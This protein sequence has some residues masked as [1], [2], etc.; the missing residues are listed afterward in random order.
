MMLFLSQNVR[1]YPFK[2]RRANCESAVT[3]LPSEA[4]QCEFPM[5][6]CGRVAFQF[7]HNVR[8][9]VSGSQSGQHVNMIAGSTYGVRNSVQVAKNAT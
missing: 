7:T 6:P 3:F 1:A 4:G 9:A 5:N 2:I 8:K